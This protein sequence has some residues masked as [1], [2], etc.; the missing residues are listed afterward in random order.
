MN[1]MIATAVSGLA[2]SVAA[3]AHHTVEKVTPPTPP[4]VAVSDPNLVLLDG[5]LDNTFVHADQQAEVIARLRIDTRSIEG[6]ERP[7]L[8]LVLAMDTSGSME[9]DAMDS[10]RAAAGEL[11]DALR[12][13]DHIAVVTFDSETRIVVPSTVISDE[14]RAGIHTAIGSMKAHG[15]TDMQGGLRQAL[16]QM[17]KGAGKDVVNRIVLL[18]DGVPND[19]SQIPALADQARN[20]GASITALGLGLEYDETL[21]GAIAQRSGGK[22]HFIEKPEQVASV[23][24]DEIARLERIVA[25]QMNLII[26]PGPG[27][28]I[29]DII[30]Q[31]VQ[32]SGRQAWVQLGDLSQ[33]ERR[34]VYVKLAVTGHA[35]GARVELLDGILT[36]QDAV[37]GAGSLKRTL[38]LG[39][40]ATG[41]AAEMEKGR[42]PEIENGAAKA[43]LAAVVVRA[44]AMARAG[45]TKQAQQ[46]IIAAEPQA[47][48]VAKRNGDDELAGK[49][50]EAKDLLQSLPSLA[51][52]QPQPQPAYPQSGQNEPPRADSPQPA[53]ATA[54]AVPMPREEASR[55]VRKAHD[56]AM[57][58][59][60]PRTRK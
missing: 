45:Q 56:R 22:F 40:R 11:V 53:P 43:A 42:N 8:N 9:G 46:M 15:T 14:T 35:G 52:A 58:S 16:Q 41:D 39:A 57:E 31:P 27:V 29:T 38:F 32:R 21:M 7:T 19:P 4:V 47:R 33:G 34:D 10:A 24:E 3:C 36:F 1:R 50:D 30:G 28:Q 49:V 18:S 2:L 26:N 54:D 17:T 51:P 37:A 48:A 44:I 20:Y 13:G 59:F 55:R 12:P 25:R 6:A 60:Q 23:F 5:A